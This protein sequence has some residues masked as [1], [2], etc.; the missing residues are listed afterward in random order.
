MREFST[1]FLACHRKP[2]PLKS[3][4]TLNKSFFFKSFHFQPTKPHQTSLQSPSIPCSFCPLPMVIFTS[5]FPSISVWEMIQFFKT[6]L[7]SSLWK[8]NQSIN[9][10]LLCLLPALVPLLISKP[11]RLYFLT[12]WLNAFWWPMENSSLHLRRKCIPIHLIHTFCYP[13]YIQILQACV[14]VS[15]HIE[16]D[17][18]W[19]TFG[20][21]SRTI[22]H[23]IFLFFQHAI[24]E[25]E[26]NL[27]LSQLKSQL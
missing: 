24:Y 17:L 14:T 19:S 15:K 7:I 11:F 22:E 27:I 2:F 21:I 26:I 6:S 25:R 5:A 20:E 13:V 16:K 23:F 12:V 8:W 10:F 9:E 3:L 18:N 4:P 1:N